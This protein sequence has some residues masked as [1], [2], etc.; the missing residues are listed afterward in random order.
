LGEQPH[1]MEDEEWTLLDWRVLG[2]VRLTLSRTV[3][4]EK[5]TAGLM[6]AL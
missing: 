3:L 5:T 4:N 6:A 1:S 2:V